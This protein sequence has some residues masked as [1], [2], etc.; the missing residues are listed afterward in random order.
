[1]HSFIISGHFLL[2]GLLLDTMKETSRRS[3]I[4]GRIVNVSSTVH[5]TPF[6]EGIRFEKINDE[7]RYY[8]EWLLC[9]CIGA[10]HIAWPLSLH[11]TVICVTSYGRLLAYRVSKLANILHANELSR[12]LI[13]KLSLASL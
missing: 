11:M 8:N 13:V 4:E 12:R 2:T 3:G 9:D 1:M 7:S 10:L 5:H 6:P